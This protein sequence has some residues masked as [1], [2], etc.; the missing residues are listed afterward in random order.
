MAKTSRYAETEGVLNVANLMCVAART[1]PKA[2]GMDNI[3]STVLTGKEKESLARKMERF[4]KTTEKPPAFARDANNVRQ[5]QAVVLIGTKFD[6]VG[7]NCGFCGFEN[8]Q[9][10]KQ[11]HSRCAHNSGDLGIAVGSAVSIASNN[12]VDSRVMYTVGWT[13]VQGKILGEKVKMVLG[14][15]LSASAKNIFFDRK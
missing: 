6:P 9:K 1:A 11:A 12:R 7:L 8:C 3:I 5:A 2:R 14:I 4:G 10:C 15:P 13:S